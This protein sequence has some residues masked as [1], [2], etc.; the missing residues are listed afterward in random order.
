MKINNTI[1]I[2]LD[3]YYIDY[4][5]LCQ[6]NK[7]KLRYKITLKPKDINHIYFEDEEGYIFMI[8]ASKN[9]FS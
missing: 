7:N 8:K 3:L 5:R 1:K 9:S 4:L 2:H 6:F